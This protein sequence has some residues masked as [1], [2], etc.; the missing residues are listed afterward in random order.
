MWKLSGKAL[1]LVRQ[2]NK[3]VN[4]KPS[5]VNSLSPFSDSKP[6]WPSVC[7]RRHGTSVLQGSLI[8][9]LV[10]KPL[11][12]NLST[13]FICLGSKMFLFFVFRLHHLV[14]F[15]FSFRALQILKSPVKFCS[16]TLSVSSQR[17][18]ASTAPT[19]RKRQW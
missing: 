7:E 19:P 16:V 14:V 6:L 15:F 2:L 5:A 8:D 18:P 9:A 3:I 4:V 13:L 10:K 1:D 12:I 17:K 11:P